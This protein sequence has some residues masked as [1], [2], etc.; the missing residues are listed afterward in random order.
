MNDLKFALRQLLKNRGFTV[1]AVS[2]LAVGL[3]LTASTLAVV[4]AYLLRSLPY[5]T[6][7]RLYHLRYAPPGPY[8]PRGMTAI[9]WKSLEMQPGDNPPE[10]FSMLTVLFSFSDF[11][12]MAD[13]RGFEPLTFA[14]VVRRSNP[15]ELRV[16][17]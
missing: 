6:A 12:R 3:A 14:S 1:V 13:P 9:D 4:N 5:P 7:Q 2:S 16:H 11:I 8:E 17:A 10:P 15:T